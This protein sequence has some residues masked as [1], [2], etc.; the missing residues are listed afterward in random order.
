MNEQLD[1]IELKLA[2]LE[3]KIDATFQSAE[4]MRKYFL[5]TLI[6]TAAVIILP[7]LAFPVVIPMFLNSLQLP[8][9][10]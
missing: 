5:W 2:E 7:L 8:A 6:I 9:N 3:G 10:F 1:R 4:K